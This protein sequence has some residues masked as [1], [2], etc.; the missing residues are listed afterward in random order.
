MFVSIMSSHSY[1]TGQH[2]SY[3]CDRISSKHKELQQPMFS[4]YQVSIK[5]PKPTR[6]SAENLAHDRNLYRSPGVFNFE[7]PVVGRS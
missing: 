5:E 2:L 7:I 6:V 3:S 4:S 1:F